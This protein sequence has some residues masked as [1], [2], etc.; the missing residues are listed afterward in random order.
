MSLLLKI[1]QL[2]DGVIDDTLVPTGDTANI[3]ILL[4]NLANRINAITGGVDWT[5]PPAYSLAGLDSAFI[6]NQNAI[7]QSSTDYRISGTGEAGKF[8][9]GLGTSV[10]DLAYS[11]TGDSNTGFYSPAAD[12]IRFV[13]AGVSRLRIEATG[14]IYLRAPNGAV[15]AFVIDASAANGQFGGGNPSAVFAQNIFRPNGSGES[16]TFTLANSTVVSPG[17]FILSPSGTTT[18]TTEPMMDLLDGGS[19]WSAPYWRI[20]RGVNNIIGVGNLGLTN[21]I[22]DFVTID[23]NNFLRRRTAADLAAD[24]VA[25]FVLNQSSVSQSANFHIDGTGAMGSLVVDTIALIGSSLSVGATGYYTSTANGIFFYGDDDDNGALTFNAVGYGV[26]TTRFRD[27]IIKDG[28]GTNILHMDGSTKITLLSADLKL[29]T[30]GTGLFIKRGTN[31]TAGIATLVGGTVTV[32]TTKVTSTMGI[33]L[34]GQNS[35]GTH[36]DLTISARSV[37]TSFTISSS[38]VLDTRD[39]YWEMTDDV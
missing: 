37:G 12:Q 18:Q 16:F 10:T 33:K 32:N 19:I 35:S 11:F 21:A 39:V 4:S 28:K 30:V 5:A 1:K 38:S 3:N 7:V 17:R 14:G 22:G 20:K 13:T 29:D 8:V 36:G 9:S 27:F 25:Q 2:E 34:T 6:R 15:D 23:A 24:L 26:S 31:A